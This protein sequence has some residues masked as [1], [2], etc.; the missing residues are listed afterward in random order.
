MGKD[1]SR[2]FDRF[3][4]IV[5]MKFDKAT[6][7]KDKKRAAERI[8]KSNKSITS[9]LEKAGKFKGRLRLMQTKHLAGKK[10]KE[11]IYR[12]NNCVFRFNIDETYFSPRLSNERKEISGKIK[13]GENVLVMFGGVAPYA[14][15]IAK[16]SKARVVSVE[17]NRKANRYA[18]LNVELNK[19]KDKVE[20]IQGDV[21]KVAGKLRKKFDVVVMPR[22]QLKESFLKLK[23]LKQKLKKQKKELKF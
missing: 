15:V 20:L 19:L 7:L 6:K 11:S 21:K 8:L 1:R 2:A 9:V 10:T 4:N 5:V 18:K 12:E 14:I 16:N 17:I 13:K 23:K 3:G 22:P